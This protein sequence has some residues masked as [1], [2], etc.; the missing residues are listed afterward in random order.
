MGPKELG[1]LQVLQCVVARCSVL[2]CVLQCTAIPWQPKNKFKVG[3]KIVAVCCRH[4]ENGCQRARLSPSIAGC[5]LQYFAMCCNV[6]Q[7][8]AMCCNVLQCVADTLKIGAKELGYL[9]VL[10]CVAV[11]CSV[12]Q[13]A[14]VYC[15]VLQTRIKWM[16]GSSAISRC[17]SVL[18][19]GTV[20]CG[21][22]CSVCCNVSQC[23]ADM[24]QIDAK[25]LGCVHV[26]QYVAVCCSVLQCV[27]V[28]CSVLQ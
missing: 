15:N 18:Q 3:A 14:V 19:Y 5:V 9:H 21:V 1:H 6:L 7:C 22:C 8:V 11:C 20:W 24:F 28:C 2:Q 17:C 23:V 13:C 16:S 26:L 4:V 10:Q 25:E 27:A 12:L